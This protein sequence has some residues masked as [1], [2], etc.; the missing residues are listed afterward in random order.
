MG[1]KHQMILHYIHYCEHFFLCGVLFILYNF[2]TISKTIYN[3]NKNIMYLLLTRSSN[4][5]KKLINKN[6]L[7]FICPCFSSKYVDVNAKIFEDTL[8]R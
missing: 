2:I 5:M 6:F 1:M 7:S 8:E 3:K 4:N